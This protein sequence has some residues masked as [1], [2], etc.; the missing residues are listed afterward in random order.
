MMNRKTITALVAVAMLALAALPAQA[1]AAFGIE[2]VS[3]AL[4]D[5]AGVPLLQ[6]G[7]HPDVT[8]TIDLKR[9]TNPETGRPTLEGNPRDIEVALPAGLVGNPNVVPH[10]SQADLISKGIAPNCDPNSQVGRAEV[11][12]NIGGFFTTF[13]LPVYAM[14]APPG[15]AGQFGF[16]LLGVL[17]FINAKVA[18]DGEYHLQTNISNI[19]QGLGIV[20]TK[21]TLWGVPAS[22]VH[23]A[24]R[25]KRAIEI[26]I[27]SSPTPSTVTPILPM[28]SNPTSCS[29]SPLGFDAHVDSWA[30]DTDATPFSGEPA[31]APLTIT[32][33]EK[34]PFEPSLEAQP[35]SHEAEAPTGLQVGIDIPQDEFEEG[36]ATSTLRDAV[37]SLPEGMTVNPAAAAGL[38]SCTPAQIGLG[39]DAPST[40]PDSSK[41]GT[42]E[43]ETPLLRRPLDGTVYQAQQG[44]NPFGS[45]L[46]MY[47]AVADPQT[48]TV[49]KL[50]GKIASDPST[51]RLQVSFDDQPQLPFEHLQVRLFGGSRAP[52]MTPPACGTYETTARFVPWSGTAPVASG[53]KFQVTSGPGGSPCPN[54]GFKPGFEAGT[55]SRGAGEYSPF[56]LR[57]DRPDGSQRLGAVDVTLPDGLLAKLSG[58][59]Y[60]SDAALAAVPSAE[61]SA[62]TQLVSPSCPAASKVGGVAVTAGAGSSPFYVDTGSAY[63]AGPYKG[64]PLS[65]AIV[66]PALAG[67]FDLGNTAV[68]VALNV[69]RK[70]T[71]VSAVSDPLPTILHGIPLDLREVRVALDR[72]E[73]TR[74]P[75]SCAPAAITGRIVGTSGAVAT[76]STPFNVAGCAN[77]GFAPKLALRVLGGTGRAAKPRLRAVLQAGPGEAN[78]GRAQV[79]LPHSLFLEQAHIKTVCTRA[80]WAQGDGNGSAC[81]ADSI[82]GKASAWSPLLDKPLEGWV[83]MRSSDHKLPD[84]VAALDGQIDIELDGRIDSG[85]NKGLR[86]TFESVPDAPVSKFVLEMKGGSKGLLVN[87]EPLC[88]KAARRHKAIVRFVGQNGKVETLRKQV[89]ATCGKART[90]AHRNHGPKGP[91]H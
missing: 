36:L 55:R 91:K 15:V 37:V 42:A 72:T 66:V 34:V 63:L 20:D 5:P 35:T 40:C 32:G 88:S 69:D 2:S 13:K 64:A 46:A 10:C 60:C 9:G 26:G 54:G 6:A 48:G 87:S 65:L 38:G 44:Q 8:T 68:R 43:I 3:A 80:Q 74:N 50:A 90:K 62:A 1:S 56:V 70:T 53:N 57:L 4:T 12:Y 81:P 61:G 78:I 19:S 67:P 22:P 7:A 24:M 76:P 47:L 23:D 75:T 77:L 25:N 86:T 89:A 85:P 45:L 79:N 27:P 82:Y 16:N 52:L 18:A 14:E 39:S 59:P 30:G 31:S 84:L 58:I 17:V 29:G 33:C 73:F 21:L 28:M 51:G 41:I 83:Y 71:Q 11:T 49:I